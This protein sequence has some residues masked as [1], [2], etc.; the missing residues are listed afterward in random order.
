[1]RII[2]VEVQFTNTAKLFG[3]LKAFQAVATFLDKNDPGNEFS[4]VVSGYYS[5]IVFNGLSVFRATAAQVY[6]YGGTLTNQQ[7][8]FFFDGTQWDFLNAGLF[9][10][11]MNEFYNLNRQALTFR[12]SVLNIAI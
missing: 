11:R 6:M 8:R 1:L 12:G 3:G 4:G 7:G 5:S 9:R 2:G 10:G